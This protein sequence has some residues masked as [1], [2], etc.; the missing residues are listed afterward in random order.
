MT[1]RGM[2]TPPRNDQEKMLAGEELEANGQVTVS[3]L[4]SIA[5]SNS[6]ATFV[7]RAVSGY[8]VSFA[9]QVLRDGNLSISEV[10]TILNNSSINPEDLADIIAQLNT[11]DTTFVNNLIPQLDNNKATD[12]VKLIDPDVTD[13]TNITDVVYFNDEIGDGEI[14]AR[15]SAQT[16]DNANNLIAHD[17]RS[18]W[19]TLFSEEPTDMSEM[20]FGITNNSH[21]IGDGNA[22]GTKIPVSYGDFKLTF[23]YTSGD[24]EDVIQWYLLRGT[25][26][27]GD[28]GLRAFLYHISSGSDSRVQDISSSDTLIDTFTS[29]GSGTHTSRLLRNDDNSIEFFNNGSSDGTNSTSDSPTTREWMSFDYSTPATGSVVECDIEEVVIDSN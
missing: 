9:S 28:G 23:S 4:A 1:I 20:P 24:T 17:F 13:L 18:P 11:D 15:E 19:G 27:L 16:S 6:S 2:A 21:D 10:A 12:G 14:I 25:D 29:F 26:S 3:D 22:Y 8:S 7:A 5:S